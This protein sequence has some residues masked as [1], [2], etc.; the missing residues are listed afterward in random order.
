MNDKKYPVA[1]IT[2]DITGSKYNPAEC[3]YIKN[4]VQTARYL[5]HKLPLLDIIVGDDDKL[6][7]IFN[8]ESSREY[9]ELWLRHELD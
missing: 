2:S 4:P 5:K 8:R 9:Y 1:D 3:V 7:F 6:V